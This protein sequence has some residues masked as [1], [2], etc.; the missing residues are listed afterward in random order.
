VLN[1]IL[2]NS[3]NK[4]IVHE[5]SFF[6]VMSF[7]FLKSTFISIFFNRLDTVCDC[8]TIKISRKELDL[9]L[10]KDIVQKT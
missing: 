2:S 7:D 3:E 8:R 4:T 1:H 10:E 6:E 9:R 5:T